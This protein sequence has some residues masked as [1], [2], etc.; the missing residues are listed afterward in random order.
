MSFRRIQTEND[1]SVIIPKTDK[2]V[3][4]CVVIKVV[5]AKPGLD[6][7]FGLKGHAIATKHENVFYS[8]GC[9]LT[10]K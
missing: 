7:D 3:K 10:L 1:Q 9:L 2:D 8:F 5:N 4:G 6:F